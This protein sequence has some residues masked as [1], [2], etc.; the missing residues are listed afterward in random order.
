[1]W[2]TAG[3]EGQGGIGTSAQEENRASLPRHGQGG[4]KTARTQ[5]AVTYMILG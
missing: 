4:T 3:E 2:A 1:M 5:Q